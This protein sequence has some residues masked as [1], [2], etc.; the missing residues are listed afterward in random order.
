MKS[1]RKA[2]KISVQKKSQNGPRQT[3]QN[4]SVKLSLKAHQVSPLTALMGK[5]GSNEVSRKKA[6]GSW[7]SNSKLGYNERSSAKANFVRYNRVV[8]RT[9]RSF[10]KKFQSRQTFGRLNK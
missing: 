9:K 6:I 5:H 7:N 10:G 1:F 2:K 8:K 3:R 4:N